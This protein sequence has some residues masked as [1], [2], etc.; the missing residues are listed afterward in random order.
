M[1]ISNA[2]AKHELELSRLFGFNHGGQPANQKRTTAAEQNRRPSQ[3]GE[4]DF[5][6]VFPQSLPFL[7]MV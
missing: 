5:A 6:A 4:A 3:K 1:A 7:Q 2:C